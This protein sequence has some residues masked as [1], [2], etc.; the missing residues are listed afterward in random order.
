MFIAWS[1]LQET[2]LMSA[3]QR[4]SGL[5]VIT[6]RVTRR[7][8]ASKPVAALDN[9]VQFLSSLLG[10]DLRWPSTQKQTLFRCKFFC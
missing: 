1:R 10:S 9:S 7:T 8:A 6:N 4:L 2:P 5:L 3:R